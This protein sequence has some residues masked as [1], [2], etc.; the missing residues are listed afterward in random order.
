MF[1]LRLEFAIGGHSLSVVSCKKPI[2][3]DYK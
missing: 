2:I 3:N 1:S